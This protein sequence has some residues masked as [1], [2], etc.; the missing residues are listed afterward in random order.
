MHSWIPQETEN[1][2]EQKRSYGSSAQGF[3]EQAAAGTCFPLPAVF[4]MV[5]MDQ[6]LGCTFLSP[7][8]WEP[9]ACVFMA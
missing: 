6:T 4:E 3:Q 2:V 9:G 7:W 5:W 8:H 1:P